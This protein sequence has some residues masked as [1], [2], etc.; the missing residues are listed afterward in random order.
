MDV[1]VPELAPR[2]HPSV[3]ADLTITVS[4]A[5]ATARTELA[6][7][8]RALVAVGAE[9]RNLIRLSS[10]I[11][12]A[13]TIVF[14]AVW[15]CGT[16]RPTASSRNLAVDATSPNVVITKIGDSGKVCIFTQNGAHLIADLNGYWT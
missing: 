11:P 10:V 3:A 15:P 12:S 2:T 1:L 16:P 6:A 8:D 14:V 7:F 5:T 9:N 13:A 4:A